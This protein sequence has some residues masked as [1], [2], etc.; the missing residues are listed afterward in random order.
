MK[1]P[2]ARKASRSGR[3]TREVTPPAIFVRVKSYGNEY[4]QARI[5]VRKG[6]YQYLVWRDGD[7]MR[8]FYLGKRT[9]HASS[10]APSADVDQAS[11]SR[12]ALRG[13]KLSSGRLPPGRARRA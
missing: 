11:S 5:R 13:T 7:K 9:P 12:S 10:P 6:C 3:K 1:S 4:A 2:R 8:E